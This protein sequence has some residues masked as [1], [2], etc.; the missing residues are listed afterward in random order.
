MLKVMHNGPEHELQQGMLN[1]I[2]AGEA[3]FQGLGT[4]VF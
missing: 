1:A 4:C 3:N 2:L